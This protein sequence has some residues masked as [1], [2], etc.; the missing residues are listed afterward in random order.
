[1]HFRSPLAIGRCRLAV[2][3]GHFQPVVV[4]Q[5]AENPRVDDSIICDI[6]LLLR[7]KIRRSSA[8]PKLSAVP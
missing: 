2:K 8:P 5:R 4:K 3:D 7:S 6:S 1:M